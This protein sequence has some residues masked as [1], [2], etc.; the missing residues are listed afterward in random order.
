[1]RLAATEY[2]RFADTV[3]AL[4]PGDWAR[5]TD[6]PAWDVRQLVC[7][8]IGMATMASNPWQTVRQQVKAYRRARATGVDPLTALTA[9]QVEE[10]A[11]WTP[12]RIVAEVRRA[13]PRAV[14]GRRRV[15]GPV[16]GRTLPQVQHVGGVAERWTIGFLNDVVL[17]RDPWLH[18][19]DLARA[20]D[21]DPVLTQD[22]DGVSWRT[23]WRSGRR[24][25]GRRTGWS[26][27]VRRATPGR[28]TG[29]VSRRPT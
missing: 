17:T 18:R 19:M 15:P 7:H 8:A 24:V 9:V 29:P 21:R 13:G 3:A 28:P 1:M 4:E 23:W 20:T 12:D 2:D 14:R 26:S 22:H 5:P 11:D 10:R 6:C 16:R 25:T 27:P